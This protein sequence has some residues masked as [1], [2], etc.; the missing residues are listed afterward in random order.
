V[1]PAGAL[2]AEALALAERVARHAPV[3]LRQAKRAVDGGLD[4]TLAEGLALE[5][6]L[7]QDCL[8]T[9]DRREALLAFAEKRAPVFTGE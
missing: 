7:Y 8:P 6:R 2:A 9:R 1:V 4:L 5:N 3:A